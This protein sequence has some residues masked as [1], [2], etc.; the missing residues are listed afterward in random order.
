MRFKFDSSDFE[1]PSLQKH[2]ASLQAIAL[3][4]DQVEDIVDYVNPDEEGITKVNFFQKPFKFLFLKNIPMLLV[5][6]HYSAKNERVQ[7]CCI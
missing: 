6:R 7:R 4:K 1:N 3:E 5:W 2:Y